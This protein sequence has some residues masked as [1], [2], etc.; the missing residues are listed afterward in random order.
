[1]DKPPDELPYSPGMWKAHA[2]GNKLTRG[3]IFDLDKYSSASKI[4]YKQFL[5]LRA[6]WITK[7]AKFLAN[8]DIRRTW[9]RDTD[10]LKAKDLL[11]SLAH[12]QAYLDPCEVSAEELRQAAFPDIGTFSLVRYLQASVLSYPQNEDFTP[13]FSPVA[14]RTRSKLIG[15]LRK[16]IDTPTRKPN[17]RTEERD[18]FVTPL[19]QRL[20]SLSFSDDD[21]S[22]VAQQS[23]G[24][25]VPDSASPVSKDIMA[26][27]PPANDEQIVNVALVLLLNA[28]TIHFVPNADWTLHRRAFQIGN[29]KSG[30]GFEARVDGFLRR[31]SDDKIMAIL[32]VKPCVRQKQRASIRMQESAQIA[33]WISHFRDDCTTRDSNGNFT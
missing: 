11:P 13:K 26:Q 28:V 30:K 21:S 23:T 25:D 5:C 27:Y 6:L 19:N 4:G 33:A 17:V 8:D 9:L 14:H 24:T 18:P 2:I 12:W 16:V 1:M 32:E 15:P 31:L 22:L 20:E 3:S 29:K 10:Y 7:Q